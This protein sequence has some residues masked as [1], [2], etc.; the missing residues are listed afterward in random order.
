MIGSVAG[1]TGGI[2][3][4]I[5][6]GD[7]APH[8]SDASDASDSIEV[9]VIDIHAPSPSPS[10]SSAPSPSAPVPSAPL[11][12]IAPIAPSAPSAHSANSAHSF[13]RSYIPREKE[14]KEEKEKVGNNQEKEKALPLDVLD[15]D[16]DDGGGDRSLCIICLDKPK[17][18]VFVHGNTGHTCC[19]HE[20][21]QAVRRSK[22][23]CPICKAK[24]DCIIR[25]FIV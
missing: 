12:H 3:G 7:V 25:N 24:I 21:A 5:D 10:P 17:N 6:I 19:C 14:I 15:D 4:I 16:G 2:F 9:T 11:V 1:G 8:I 22:G 18:G 13:N 20:C 23:C